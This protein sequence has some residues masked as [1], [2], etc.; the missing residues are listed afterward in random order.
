MSSIKV[1]IDVSYSQICLFESRL[2]HPFNGWSERHFSQ[3][4]SWRDCSVSFV[5]LLED[6]YCEVNVYVDEPVPEL[7][8]DVVRAFKV[9]LIISDDMIEI[10]SI[11]DTVRL[12]IS[13]GT[14]VL[15]M[16][17]LA[18]S[19]E[20]M[21]ANIRLNMGVGQIEV[22]RADAGIDATSELDLVAGPSL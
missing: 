21:Y 2:E 15:Q 16:E 3:G 11:S 17:L 8:E 13:P 12:P 14:Y 4:F 20:L 6:G 7:G 18:A 1:K 22:L 5:T 9:P 10:G 19:D